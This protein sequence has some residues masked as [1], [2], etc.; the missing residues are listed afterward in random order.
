MSERSFYESPLGTRYASEE[1]RKL[2]SQRHR[3]VLWRKLWLYLAEEERSLGIEIPESAITAMQANLENIDFEA[4]AAYEKE[5]RHDVMAHVHAFGDAAPEAR[6][7]IH[8]GA[9]SCYVTDNSDLMI[10]RRGLELLLG[11]LRSTISHLRDFAVEHARTPALAYTHFQPAQLTTIGKRATLW[12]YDFLRDAEAVRHLLD[13]I[14]F[15]GCKGTTG[16]QASFLELFSG[17]GSRVV[18]LDSRIA[19]RCGF[20]STVP[21]SGQTYTR[22]IDSEILNALAGIAE[23]ASKFGNDIRLLQHERELL[24]PFGGAQVGSSAMPYKRNPM[25]SE[26][27][28]ALARFVIS[29]RENGSYTAAT[30]WLERTLDDSANRRLA[31]A[32]AFLGTDAVLALTADISSGLEVRER[33]VAAHVEREMPFM[34]SERWLM[35]GVRAGGDRQ[36]LHESIRRHSMAAANSIDGGGENDLL[37]RLASD[38]LF[39]NVDRE[40][41]Q[42]ELDPARYIGRAGEQVMEFITTHVDEMLENTA[43]YSN[44]SD[45]AITV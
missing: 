25:R 44:T 7:F 13:T 32:E 14:P 21:V 43:Q 24:E 18:E 30:Q 20:Q 35:L 9:T 38:P 8:L 39:V 28:C 42:E 4:V 17:D 6:R 1:M 33:V 45:P 12:I 41:L 16:T 11:R 29:L 36:E 40:R 37:D 26:R 31:I 22:K 3:S 15:R 10:M 23:S 34:A 5:F 19:R 27:V 2:F